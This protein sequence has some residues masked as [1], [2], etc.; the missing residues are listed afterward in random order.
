MQEPPVN[1]FHESGWQLDQE[2]YGIKW[3]VL[4]PRFPSPSRDW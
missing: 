1:I 3:K 2:Q 4:L